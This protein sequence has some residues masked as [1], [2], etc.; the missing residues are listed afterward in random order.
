MVRTKATPEETAPVDA[1]PPASPGAD[2]PVNSLAAPPAPPP[3]AP[4]TLR[5]RGPAGVLSL[6]LRTTSTLADFVAAAERQLAGAVAHAS[7]RGADGRPVTLLSDG[8][9]PA[10][11]ALLIGP[12]TPVSLVGLDA[13]AVV[14]VQVAAKK[15]PA[16]RAKAPKAAAAKRRKAAD[17]DDDGDGDG[18][19][20]EVKKLLGGRAHAVLSGGAAAGDDASTVAAAFVNAN[21]SSDGLMGAAASQWVSQQGALR[22]EAASKAG[23]VRVVE[24]PA[25]LRVYWKTSAR[26]KKETEESVRKFSPAESIAVVAAILHRQAGSN[27]RKLAGDKPSTRLLTPP[28]VASR[29]PAL[30]WSLYASSRPAPDEPGD[31]V[32]A[33][34][35]VLSEALA[36]YRADVD[37][38]RAAAEA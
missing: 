8:A 37:A 5:C 38:L 14:N 19:E 13:S 2:A 34:D 1:A 11:G 30:F 4:L 28:A 24:T 33:L 15:K 6:A 36:K 27:R 17:D 22:V 16:K 10:G 12:H 32:F 25:K 9:Y 18:D 20:A 26:A 7:F 3:S 21:E 31:V 29:C 23:L 35:H